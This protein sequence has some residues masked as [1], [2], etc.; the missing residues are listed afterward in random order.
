MKNQSRLCQHCK[1]SFSFVRP[2][3][4]AGCNFSKHYLLQQRT[5]HLYSLMP[6]CEKNGVTV[7]FCPYIR[8]VP[9][10][11]LA[12]D[13]GYPNGDFRGSPQSLQTNL[14]QVFVHKFCKLITIFTL[15]FVQVVPYFCNLTSIETRQATY[16]QLNI[17]ERCHTKAVSI[18]SSECVSVVLVMQHAQS[19][20]AVLHGHQWPL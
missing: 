3:I 20:C 11:N 4:S 2:P 18:T 15:Y 12:R 19:A 17:Q 9:G 10:F 16:V 1:I 13:T 14:D 5:F 8:K 7:T 6:H